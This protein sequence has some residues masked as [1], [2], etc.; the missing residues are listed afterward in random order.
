MGKDEPYAVC[1]ECTLSIRYDVI[2]ARLNAVEKLSAEDARY[3]MRTLSETNHQHIAF[4]LR[5]YADALDD[6]GTL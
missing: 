4:V 2:E 5:A 3:A 6:L 1:Y